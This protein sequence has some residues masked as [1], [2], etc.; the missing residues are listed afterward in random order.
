MHKTICATFRGKPV[1]NVET[2]ENSRKP[3]LPRA[4]LSKV[5]NTAHC[6]LWKGYNF[7][8]ITKKRLDKNKKKKVK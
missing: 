4:N 6:H 5:G 3:R 1:E 8:K 2:V 7:I